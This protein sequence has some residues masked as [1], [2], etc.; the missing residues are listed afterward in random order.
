M[1]KVTREVLTSTSERKSGFDTA[2]DEFETDDDRVLKGRS[3][4]SYRLGSRS[5]DFRST[6]EGWLIVTFIAGQNDLL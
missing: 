4:T 3:S 5:K 6:D 2:D 1:Y